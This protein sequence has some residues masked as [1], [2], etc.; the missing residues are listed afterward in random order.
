MKKRM[1]KFPLL[2]ALFGLLSLVRVDSTMAQATT[3]TTETTEDINTTVAGCPL[4]DPIQLTG[5]LYIRT[6]V[7][8][9]DKGR[10][11]V[12]M[13]TRYQDLTATDLTTG[14]QYVITESENYAQNS[15]A[16]FEFAPFE[17]TLVQK[18]KLIKQGE[19]QGQGRVDDDLMMRVI[20]HVTNN[21]NGETTAFSFKGEAICK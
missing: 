2:I 12:E 17:F 3:M 14:E 7:T 10:Y 4:G 16:F 8:I 5:K 9:T 19:A 6:H 21:A 11:H 18:M 13:Q 15:N 1:W 20:S